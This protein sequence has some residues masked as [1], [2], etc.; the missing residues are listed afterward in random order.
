MEKMKYYAPRM[1]IYNIRVTQQLMSG[2]PVPVDPNSSVDGPNSLGRE[3][4]FDD[5]EYDY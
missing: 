2:S 1:E 5:D 3:M 4:D